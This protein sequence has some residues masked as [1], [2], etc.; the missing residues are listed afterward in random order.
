MIAREGRP[1]RQA[2]YLIRSG[3]VAI[4]EKDGEDD[5]TI[6]AE[7]DYFGD[8]SFNIEDMFISKST[9]TA[10]EQTKC[11]M[12]TLQDIRRVVGRGV[13]SSKKEDAVDKR[14]KSILFEDIQR[15]TILGAGTFGQVWLVNKKGT[16][17]VYAL[18]I[19]NK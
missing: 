10:V 17:D 18:K 13:V 5:V 15:R 9:I 6:L 11:K 14:D 12:L 4:H 16:K 7:G 2:I 8:E 19:Q 3:K 1:T